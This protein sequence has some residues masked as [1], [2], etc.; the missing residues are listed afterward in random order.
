MIRIDIV[1]ANHDVKQGKFTFTKDH[2]YFCRNSKCGND[3]VVRSNENQWV[4]VIDQCYTVY[5]KIMK[6]FRNDFTIVNTVFVKNYEEAKQLIEKGIDVHVGGA[7]DE[8]KM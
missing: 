3:V 4:S 1:R 6:K 2:Y 5:Y 8:G 7:E